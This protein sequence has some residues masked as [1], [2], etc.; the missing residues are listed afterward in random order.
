MQAENRQKPTFHA[1]LPSNRNLHR[2]GFCPPYDAA[3]RS[4]QTRETP[5][6]RAPQV[7]GRPRSPHHL[8]PTRRGAPATA[9]LREGPSARTRAARAHVAQP[10]GRPGPASG[11]K[12]RDP[13]GE[14]PSRPGSKGLAVDSWGRAGLTE[15]GRLLGDLADPD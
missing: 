11:T 4:Q 9:W 13:N 12:L 10:Q 8:V 15:S 7:Q 1:N 6:S 2:T 5:L 3:G 14:P